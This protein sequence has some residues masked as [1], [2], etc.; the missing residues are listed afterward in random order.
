VRRYGEKK[1]NFSRFETN[2]VEASQIIFDDDQAQLNDIDNDRSTSNPVESRSCSISFDMLIQSDTTTFDL[3][4]PGSNPIDAHQ[5]QNYLYLRNDS[6]TGAL[7]LKCQWVATW[8][9]GKT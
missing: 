9:R 4:L 5:L 1:D 6:C 7:R 2:H 3:I 8:A